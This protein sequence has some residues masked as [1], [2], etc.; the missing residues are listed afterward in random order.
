MAGGLVLAGGVAGRLGL[1]VLVLLRVGGVGRR[2]WWAWASSPPRR[3]AA[4][5]FRPCT[6]QTIGGLLL[7]AFAYRGRPG[8]G[9]VL[10]D[11]TRRLTNPKVPYIELELELELELA[12]SE[13]RRRLRLRGVS[14]SPSIVGGRAT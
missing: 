2:N 11:E 14:S 1:L 6:I 10:R 7:L 3:S 8:G 5:V 12:A 13:S 4:A 9:G